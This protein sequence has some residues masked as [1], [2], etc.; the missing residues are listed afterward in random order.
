MRGCNVKKIITTAQKLQVLEQDQE[1]VLSLGFT[2]SQ[3]LIQV[4]TATRRIYQFSIPNGKSSNPSPV[5]DLW[6]L[7][8]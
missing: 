6:L 3:F 8:S 1:Y 4:P 2:F 7:S 5:T